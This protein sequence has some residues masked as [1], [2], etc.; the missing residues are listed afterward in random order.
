MAYIKKQNRP[1]TEAG[2]ILE[3]VISCVPFGLVVVCRSGSVLHVNPKAKRLLALTPSL[4]NLVGNN[5]VE[6]VKHIPR[7]EEKLANY[8]KNPDQKFSLESVLFK[9]RYL[10]I[11]AHKYTKG[12]I[13]TINDITKLKALESYSVQAIITA[14]EKERRRLS[15]EIHDGIAPLLSAAKLELEMF[16][17]KMKAHDED[18]PDEQLLNIRNTIDSISTDL[19]NM[20]HLL[21]PRLLEEFGL[22]SAIQNMVTRLERTTKSSIDFICN[23]SPG[24]RFER[25]IELNIYRCFQ[26]M[27]SNAIQYACAEK[28]T[29]QLIKHVASIVLMVEDDGVGFNQEGLST[30]DD[31]IGLSN[32][33][34]RTRTLNGEFL[35]ESIEGKGTLVS[36]ELPA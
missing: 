8:F 15:R 4:E 14:Q 10:D 27:M 9:K 20:S 29:V 35:V 6:Q 36:I 7:I 31:G 11:T 12:F 24:E 18:I 28:I 23:F 17:E 2:V 19:R 5:I 3:S 13:I 32:I 30:E 33:Q 21:M 26:E 34:T 16:L 22:L 1:S 25:E